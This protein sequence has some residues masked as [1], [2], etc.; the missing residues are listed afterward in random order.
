MVPMHTIPFVLWWLA[1]GRR[2]DVEGDVDNHHKGT[3]S[4]R[5]P[6][7]PILNLLLP[8]PSYTPFQENENHYVP[9][10]PPRLQYRHYEAWEEY[11]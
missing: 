7:N 10:A 9:L 3:K 8:P 1:L 4:P 5:P 6:L 11:K 2:C